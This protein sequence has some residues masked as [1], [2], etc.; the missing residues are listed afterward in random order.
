[1]AFLGSLILRLN[2]LDL[3][4]R[5]MGRR[6]SR[7][8]DS[9]RLAPAVDRYIQ[10][11][12]GQA[13]RPSRI[14]QGGPRGATARA[15]YVPFGT[16]LGEGQVLSA[17]VNPTHYADLAPTINSP[18][19]G[20]AVTNDLG[21]DEL[22]P[23]TGVRPARVVWFR[24]ATRSVQVATSDITGLKYLKYAGERS[25]CP[26]G[27]PSA[28]STSDLFDAFSEIKGLLLDRPGL[29]INRVSLIREDK[30]Y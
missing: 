25:A 16:D 14:G 10:Y 23:V 19:T 26:F 5:A 15:F 1:M 3:R 11:L 7:I 4:T 21:A 30:K 12:T 6:Y 22:S 24:N 18:G 27:R 28:N 17:S 2:F 13:Q 29:D 9:A 8:L 20:A